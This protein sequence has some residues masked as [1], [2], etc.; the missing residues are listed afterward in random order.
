M[1]NFNQ[2]FTHQL[3]SKNKVLDLSSPKVMGILNVTPD[4]FSDGGKFYHIDSALRHCESMIC[5]GAD[6][7][8]IGGESTRPFADAVT[9]KQEQ[10]RVLPVIQAIRRHF[11]DE[12]WL[13]LDTSCPNLMQ[14]GIEA[15]AD[16]INDVRALTREGALQAASKLNVPVVLMHHRGNPQTMNDLANYQDVIAEVFDE[17]NQNVQAALQA[18]ILRQNLLIDVGMGFAKSYQHHRILMRQLNDLIQ[19]FQLPMLFGVSRK[20]FVG[21]LLSNTQV[22]SFKNHNTQDKDV[23]TAA[24]GLLAVQA[25]ASIVRVHNVAYSVQML[26]MWQ[27][28]SDSCR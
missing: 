5:D 3:R 7:I 14:S 21:E 9:S 20:R 27:Q 18:G 15:G 28:I 11:G 12:I 6:I 1:L 10:E 25:G 8:D 13:S 23:L 22:K 16:M 26:S 24:L 4:S 17:L 2:N 19:K